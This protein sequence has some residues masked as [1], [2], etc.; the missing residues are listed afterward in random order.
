MTIRTPIFAAALALAFASPGAAL[1][2]APAYH[3]GMAVKDA[4]G[5]SVGSVVK[6]EGDVITVKTDKHEVPLP[7]KS[8]TVDGHTLLLGMTQ[9]QLNSEWE[10]TLASAEASL[11]VGAPVLGAQG[12]PVGTIDAI[13]AETVTI[14]LANGKK[15]RLPRNGIVGNSGGARIGFTAEQ[16][17]AQIAG[18]S[19]Q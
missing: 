3:P 11:A 12:T 7:A 9:A 8:F 14:A 13:D 16:L 18:S 5:G 4:S 1:A 15:V 2:Q 6:V 17:E 19:G 10:K